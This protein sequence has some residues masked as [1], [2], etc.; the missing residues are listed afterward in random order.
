MRQPLRHAASRPTP[1]GDAAIKALRAEGVSVEHVLRGGERLG[2]YFAET[3]A[4]QRAVDGDLRPRAF[5]HQR[6]ARRAACRGTT[7]STGA[8]WFHWTGITPALSASAAACTREAIDAAR[9]RR[10]AR[11]SVD[12]NY[13]SKLWS[14]HDAQQTMRPLMPLVDLVIANEEDLQAVLGIDVPHA[15]VDGGSARRRRL[16]R[17]RRARGARVRRRRRSP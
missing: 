10:R 12:L 15:D 8:A 3:G 13:R 9:A 2:I 16:S 6:A 14:E 7:S 17:R 1:I 5:G 4:S 11:V